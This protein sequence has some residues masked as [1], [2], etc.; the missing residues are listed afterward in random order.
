MISF[1]ATGRIASELEVSKMGNTDRQILKFTLASNNGRKNTSGEYATSF[2]YCTVF[3]PHLIKYLTE[4]AQKGGRISISGS[5]T[6]AYVNE[7]NYTNFYVDT[8]EYLETKDES[9]AMKKR[10]NNNSNNN[11][12]NNEYYEASEKSFEENDLPF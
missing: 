9:E 4:Y 1:N 3:N 11:G 10:G 2:I 8:A 12:G 7:K 5:L 6:Q